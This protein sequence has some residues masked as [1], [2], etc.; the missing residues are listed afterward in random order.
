MSALLEGLVTGLSRA[1]EA[2]DLAAA[3]PVAEPEVQALLAAARVAPSADNLQTWRFIVVRE[4][5]LRQDLGRA[6]PGELSSTVE[7]APLVIVACGVK[8]I[9]KGVRSE[10]PFVMVDVP[11]AVVHLLLE[12]KELGLD[13]GW[14]LDVDEV[15]MRE[16]LG[17]PAE[18]RVIALLALGRPG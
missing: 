10:Q 15:R 16:I 9:I 4:E 6:V 5:R 12:A 7:H 3:Q 17:I 13:C 2:R 14:T 8:A 11:I 1:G 18:V